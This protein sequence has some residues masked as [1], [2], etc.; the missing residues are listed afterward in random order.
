MSPMTADNTT[1]EEMTILQ[2]VLKYTLQMKQYCHFYLLLSFK[3]MTENMKTLI[4]I[5][6]GLVKMLQE[7][8]CCFWCF[9]GVDGQDGEPGKDGERGQKVR[10]LYKPDI[11]AITLL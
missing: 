2:K 7:F 5:L 8:M 11:T 6:Q 4:Q 9:Q 1:P 10:Y 3:S